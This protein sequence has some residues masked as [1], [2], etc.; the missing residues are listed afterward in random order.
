[1]CQEQMSSMTNGV[2]VTLIGRYFR[3]K[4]S[5]TIMDY[6][7]QSR[8]RII[9]GW[10]SQLPRSPHRG[11]P[12][13]QV[14]HQQAASTGSLARGQLLQVRRHPAHAMGK[15]SVLE[16]W[17]WWTSASR[18]WCTA[19]PGS[20]WPHILRRSASTTGT[21]QYIFGTKKIEIHR[22]RNSFDQVEQGNN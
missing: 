7:G 10:W 22:I 17:R 13:H 1:M 4:L 3:I 21:S 14:S 18:P 2:W 16:C 15:G 11:L 12:L 5:L 8:L 9:Q 20:S 19:S 6:Y